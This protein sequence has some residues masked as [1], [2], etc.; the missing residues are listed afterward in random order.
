MNP[1]LEL[2][3]H[4]QI[5]SKYKSSSADV[6]CLV[7]FPTFLLLNC[8]LLVIRWYLTFIISKDSKYLISRPELSF[9]IIVISYIPHPFFSLGWIG[10]NAVLLP[11]EMK[12]T[13][14][15]LEPVEDILFVDSQFHPVWVLTLLIHFRIFSFSQRMYPENVPDYQ[16][17]LTAWPAMPAPDSPW[18]YG[19][20]PHSLSDVVSLVCESLLLSG[21]NKLLVEFFSFKVGVSLLYRSFDMSRCSVIY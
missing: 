15:L 6:D 2:N 4:W 18:F 17:Y 12:F 14:L 19:L 11:A 8:H 7:S 9:K 3:T 21:R 5:P 10:F 1:Q 20:Y 16:E 13:E